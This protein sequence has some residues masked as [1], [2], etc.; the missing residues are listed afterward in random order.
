MN[1][2]PGEDNSPILIKINECT[3]R[4]VASSTEDLVQEKS[5][6][7][8]CEDSNSRLGRGWIS[9]GC[10]RGSSAKVEIYLGAFGVGKVGCP[11]MVVAG[12][13]K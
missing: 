6:E 9:R 10:C 8:H 7:A 5:Q 11:S 2:S 3:Y 12:L 13:M 1:R 4:T